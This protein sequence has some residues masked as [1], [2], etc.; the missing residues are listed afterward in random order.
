MFMCALPTYFLDNITNIIYRL[1]FITYKS[2]LLYNVQRD[3]KDDFDRK[4][5]TRHVFFIIIIII[6]LFHIL[7][8]YTSYYYI[9]II[10]FVTEQ[11]SPPSITRRK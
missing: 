2:M 7:F 4:R 6:L 10:H 9:Y 11:Y 3:V 5:F 8:V 1:G